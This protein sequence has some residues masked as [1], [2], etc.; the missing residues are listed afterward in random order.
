MTS[1]S[2]RHI[3]MLGSW[4]GRLMSFIKVVFCLRVIAFPLMLSGLADIKM[5]T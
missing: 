1:L 5:R 2:N 4:V 3:G